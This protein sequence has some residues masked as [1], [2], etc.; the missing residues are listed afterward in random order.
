MKKDMV[1]RKDGSMSKR[2]L[3]DN[4]LAKQKE[5]KATG[6]K[7]NKPTPEM[8]KQMKKIKNK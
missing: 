5:N 4:I 1:K 2:G 8:K 6:K 7:P 3:Y